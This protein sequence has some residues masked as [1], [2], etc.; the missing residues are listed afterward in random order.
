MNFINLSKEAQGYGNARLA[1]GLLTKAKD[2]LFNDIVTNAIGSLKDDK[3]VIS[4]M[5]L[6]RSIKEAREQYQKGDLGGAYELILKREDQD[7]DRIG[8]K[9]AETNA[10]QLYSQAIDMLQKVW[11]KMKQEEDKGK[12]MSK[13]QS[14]I[15]DAKM[16]LAGGDYPKVLSLCDE[17]MGAIQSPQDRLK[18]EVEDTVEEITSTLKA[19]FPDD[20]RSPKERLFNKQIQELLSQSQKALKPPRLSANRRPRK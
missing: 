15:K 11:L 18:E 4:K 8:K 7:E 3:D 9:G 6:E 1:V 16:V 17:V 14:L 19:L 20:P 12:D 13:A 10:P 2:Q 5:R